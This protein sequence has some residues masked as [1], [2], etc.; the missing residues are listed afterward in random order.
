MVSGKSLCLSDSIFYPPFL[1]SWI[2]GRGPRR[3]PSPHDR[4]LN[5]STPSVVI[6]NMARPGQVSHYSAFCA[7]RAE[8][9][10]TGSVDLQSCEFI[11]PTT[12]V[13]LLALSRKSEWPWKVNPK[14]QVRGYLNYILNRR[15]SRAIG[16]SYVA[17]VSL[18]SSPEDFKNV[19]KGLHSLQSQSALFR[20]NEVAYKYVIGELVDNIYE[21]SAF[22]HASVMGQKYAQGGYIELCFFDDGITIPGSFVKHGRA[23][24]KKAHKDAIIEA[25][26]GAS[27]K[28]EKG[29][30]YG[31]STNVEMFRD[32][33]GEVFIASGY[34]AIYVDK[35]GVIPYTLDDSS[36]MEGTLI[37]LRVR[38]RARVV[39]VYEYVERESTL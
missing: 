12:L 36:R 24:D 5:W 19:L 22:Q 25:V 30:G 39:N 10:R 37:S 34:G 32:I 27:T 20:R 33:G 13:P 3:S 14:T 23:Y 35:G 31:L 9:R 8:G 38:D 7:Y 6:R 1:D 2:M 4:L 18:P 17:P 29:R 15:G 16:S 26:K 28:Q 21:H 11:Y